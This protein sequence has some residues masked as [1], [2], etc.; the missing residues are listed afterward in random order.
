MATQTS[1]IID[2]DRYEKVARA[3]AGVP[4]VTEEVVEKITAPVQAAVEFAA[5]VFVTDLTSRAYGLG[6]I[7]G[8]GIVLLTLALSR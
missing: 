7:T 6:V 4:E 8:A 3:L 1:D 2:T 5:P